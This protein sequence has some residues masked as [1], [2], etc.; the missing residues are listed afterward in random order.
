MG[1]LGQFNQQHQAKKFLTREELISQAIPFC[2]NKVEEKSGTAVNKQ[3]GQ[4]FTY[5][6]L[7][8]HFTA[9]HEDRAYTGQFNLPVNK[10]RQELI[11]FVEENGG[12]PQHNW[13][14]EK[15]QSNGYMWFSEVE[16]DLCPCSLADGLQAE[17]KKARKEVQEIKE[18][19]ATTEQKMMIVENRGALLKAGQDVA[20]PKDFD[21]LTY[22][23]AQ[24]FIAWQESLYA[25]AMAGARK[26]SK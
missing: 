20:L 24:Q 23:R 7:V 17:H 25:K 3:T 5:H 1:I 18:G 15:G 16:Q 22:E 26:K 19:E 13:L 4:E 11:A 10:Q 6:N 14:L 12:W 9:V 2:V 8:F 21:T